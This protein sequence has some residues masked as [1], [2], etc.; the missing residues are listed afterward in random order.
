MARCRACHRHDVHERSQREPIE[1]RRTRN[2]EQVRR[3]RQKLKQEVFTYYC[4]GLAPACRCCGQV[5]LIFLTIDHIDN[6]GNTHR[7]ELAANILGDKLPAG[8]TFYVWLRRN[9]FPDGYQVLCW[10]CNAAKGF[11]GGICPHVSSPESAT[12]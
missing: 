11:N 4:D 1:L 12:A 10:N 9:N 7:R 8:N 2:K 3:S 5:G 6:T